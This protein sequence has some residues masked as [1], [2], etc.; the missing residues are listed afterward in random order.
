MYWLKSRFAND[1]TISSLITSTGEKYIPNFGESNGAK[2]FEL[3]SNLFIR[4]NLPSLPLNIL[5]SILIFVAILRL[6]PLF[7]IIVFVLSTTDS[8]VLA[9]LKPFAFPITVVVWLELTS[10]ISLVSD[11]VVLSSN[12]NLLAKL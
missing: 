12:E 2:S 1:D 3:L 9:P 10:R 11:N 6:G 7:G 4:L 8:N 5:S